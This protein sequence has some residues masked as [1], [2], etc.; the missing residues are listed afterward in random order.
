M[1]SGEVDQTGDRHVKRGG[2]RWSDALIRR[3]ETNKACILSCNDASEKRE[4][5]WG[6]EC[7]GGSD[8]MFP[9]CLL[10]A[11]ARPVLARIASRMVAPVDGLK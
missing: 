2:K 4:S 6:G 10:Y 8:W 3:V 9:R 7:V 1:A 11:V 5:S